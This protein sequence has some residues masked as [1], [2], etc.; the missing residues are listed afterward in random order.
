VPA[1]R[2]NYAICAYT[3]T[4]VLN[5]C[6]AIDV[7]ATKGCRPSVNTRAPVKNTGHFYF[8]STG[9]YSS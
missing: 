6:I 4:A 7:L 5:V 1:Y 3:S 8:P 2:L 9:C